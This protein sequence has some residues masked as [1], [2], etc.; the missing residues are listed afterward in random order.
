MRFYK[1][2]YTAVDGTVR[3]RRTWCGYA[4]DAGKLYEAFW[5]LGTE[6]IHIVEPV[7]WMA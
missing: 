3:A 4:H 5:K 6:D 7:G 1:V 2:Y